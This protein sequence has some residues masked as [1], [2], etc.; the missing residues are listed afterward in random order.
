MNYFKAL[1][2]FTIIVFFGTTLTG[3]IYPSRNSSDSL[4]TP[5]LFNPMPTNP[6]PFLTTAPKRASDAVLLSDSIPD[7]LFQKGSRQLVI[8]REILKKLYH[9]TQLARKFGV[10]INAQLL[11]ENNRIIDIFYPDKVEELIVVR[12]EY[13]NERHDS[14]FYISLLIPLSRLRANA[15]KGNTT[16]PQHLEQLAE[17]LEKYQSTLHFFKEN[18]EEIIF[19]SNDIQS[20]KLG[21]N[22]ERLKSF[23]QLLKERRAIAT[24][25]C[26]NMWLDTTVYSTYS[27]YKI[28]IHVHP[29]QVPSPPSKG[30][31]DQWYFYAGIPHGLIVQTLEGDRLFMFYEDDDSRKELFMAV[32]D[33]F[34]KAFYE[35][36]EEDIYSHPYIRSGV[37]EDLKQLAMAP[38]LASAKKVPGQPASNFT[39][40]QLKALNTD[41]LAAVAASL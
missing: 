41:G 7:L 18:G 37:L 11:E 23:L 34:W 32:Y 30:D 19:N 38:N 21:E 39:V 15:R 9:M 25:W 2:L 3:P 17:I 5:S 20:L 16:D 27:K 6:P 31:Q 40:T 10:E 4:S 8:P 1:N 33:R 12:T 26:A 14:S 22:I 13:N 36:D 28:S 29:N 24:A 35:L